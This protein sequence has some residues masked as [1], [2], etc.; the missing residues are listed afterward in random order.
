MENYE[1]NEDS[2]EINQENTE[3]YIPDENSSEEDIDTLQYQ[4][5]YDPEIMNA[6]QFKG[7]LNPT[8]EFYL[9]KTNEIP[10]HI[11]EP[12]YLSINPFEKVIINGYPR[13]GNTM[14]RKYLEDITGTIT[15]TDSDNRRGLSSF[16]IDKGFKGQ[17]KV[18][19]V[20]WFVK[21]HFPERNG[22]KFLANKCI[23]LVRNPID[24]IISL[25]NMIATGTHTLSIT[26]EDFE[27]FNSY[28]D[29]FLGEE[30][31]VWRDFYSYWMDHPR[32]PTFVVRYEDL[33]S[34][35]K[36]TLLD[37]FRFL[38]NEKDL[39]GTLIENLINSHTQPKVKKEV[40]KPRKGKINGNRY[41]YK[42]HQIKKVK[43]IAG[44][45]LKR[46]GYVN[47]ENNLDSITGFYSDDEDIKSSLDTLAENNQD[48]EI[49]I[50][51]R[52]HE[53]NNI[54]LDNVCSDEYRN[55]VKE[56]DGLS[57]I[58]V[59]DPNELIRKKSEEDP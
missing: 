32:I 51:C 44:H 57:S 26:D 30:I 4:P 21:T 36:D 12:K 13:S 52:Y 39:D 3:F 18:N 38:L 10:G 7:E 34:K 37:L 17:G 16:L 55:Q 45:M 11:A 56:I 2:K 48:Q 43:N 47:D 40:Y 27:K 53:Y 31:V 22:I 59:N 46:M 14:I 29:Q 28:F 58:E 23:L 6:S 42:D 8:Y 15:G 54:N 41:L 5:G 9:M 50:G 1:H 25:Y 49:E 33:L 20:V 35:P 19:D 24:S